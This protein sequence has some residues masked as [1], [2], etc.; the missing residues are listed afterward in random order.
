ML[1]FKTVR[2]RHSASAR[3]K[4]LTALTFAEKALAFFFA[5]AKN[6]GDVVEGLEQIDI[7]GAGVEEDG[8]GD[9]EGINDAE[10][11]TGVGSSGE[12]SSDELVELQDEEESSIFLLKRRQ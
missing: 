7:A 8:L 2:L 5:K 4:E 9:L 12:L 10:S 6:W 11:G 1:L 3:T